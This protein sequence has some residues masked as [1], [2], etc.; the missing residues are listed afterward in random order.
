MVYGVVH[1]GETNVVYTVNFVVNCFRNQL[2]RELCRELARFAAIPM[3]AA[4]IDNSPC[5]TA[6]PIETN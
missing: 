2:L 3:N 5:G 4:Q 1:V 6:M